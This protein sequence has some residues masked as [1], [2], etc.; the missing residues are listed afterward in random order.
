MRW[1]EIRGYFPV[2]QVRSYLGAVLI[3]ALNAE[4][5]RST[6]NTAG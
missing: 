4:Y 3:L 6:Q 2:A 5:F 1:P